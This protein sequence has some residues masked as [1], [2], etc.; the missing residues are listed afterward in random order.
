M[1][2]VVVE[3]EGDVREREERRVWRVRLGKGVR[4]GKAGGGVALC[5]ANV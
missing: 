5:L 1:R 2:C 4:A 3:G